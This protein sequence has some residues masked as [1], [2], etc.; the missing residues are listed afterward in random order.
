[1]AE[2]DKI[3]KVLA[4]KQVYVGY[5]EDIERFVARQYSIEGTFY[6]VGSGDTAL[7][8][9]ADAIFYLTP[10]PQEK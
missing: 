2:I 1:M 4:E 3:L 6:E 8:A 10:K 9:A 7:Q 5:E